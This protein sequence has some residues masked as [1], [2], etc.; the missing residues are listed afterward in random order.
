MPPY[1]EASP[2]PSAAQRAGALDQW[3]VLR[4]D[5]R[6]LAILDVSG[7]MRFPAR[8]TR[9][10]TRAKV[11]EE[12]AVTALSILPA[13]SSIG[14]WVLSTDQRGKGVDYSELA[15]VEH[16]STPP[17]AGRTGATTSSP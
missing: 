17:I 3:H 13:G 10:M 7:S 5:M 6:M 15:R 16:T 14:A 1:T 9:G 2:A 4:T 11:A 8:D 12:A